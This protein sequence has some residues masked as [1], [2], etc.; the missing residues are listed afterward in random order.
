MFDTRAE[1]LNHARE[2]GLLPLHIA[3]STD[4]VHAPDVISWLLTASLIKHEVRYKEP[5]RE[6][7][8]DELVTQG[9][10]S[11]ARD[12]KRHYMSLE[13]LTD[14][15]SGGSSLATEYMKE[16]MKEEE[17]ETIKNDEDEESIA[18]DAGM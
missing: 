7:T 18:F 10:N 9:E 14:A 3:A 16:L 13:T 2:D 11:I 15:I 8:L 17:S 5:L 4:S 12:R 1:F 6:K